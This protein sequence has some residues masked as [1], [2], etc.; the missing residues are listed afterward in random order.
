MWYVNPTKDA[1]LGFSK[2]FKNTGFYIKNTRGKYKFFRKVNNTIY[3]GVIF[4]LKQAKRGHNTI[5]TG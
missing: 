3:C 5:K 2:T 1:N 4:P